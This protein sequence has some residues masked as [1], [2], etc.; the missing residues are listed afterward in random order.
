[1]NM[2]ACYLAMFNGFQGPNNSITSGA[3]SANLALTEAYRQIDDGDV[4][5]MLV[6][7]TGSRLSPLGLVHA[8]AEEE[9]ATG[10]DDPATVCRPFDRGRTGAVP[11]EGAAAFVLEDADSAHRRGATIYG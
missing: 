5:A 4:D 1:P 8:H 3:V 10:E 11:A 2:P 9:I 6:G 7:A